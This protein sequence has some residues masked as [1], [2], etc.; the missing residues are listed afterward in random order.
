MP[1]GNVFLDLKGL[2]CP[3]PALMAEKRARRL[4]PGE[5]LVIE[6]TDPMA[7]VDIG[8]LASDLALAMTL[9]REGGV[10]RITLEKTT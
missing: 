4:Q 5:R 10:L 9:C 2:L 3:L 1:M 7:E 8:V 6:A